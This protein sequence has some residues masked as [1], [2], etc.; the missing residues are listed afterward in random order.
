MTYT[1]AYLEYLE[2]DEWKAKRAAKL[3]EVGGKCEKWTAKDCDCAGLLQ[4]HHKNYDRLGHELMSDLMVL[5]EHHHK[6]EDQKRQFEAARMRHDKA[7][8]SYASKK[9]GEMWNEY[10]NADM[11]TEEFD[12]WAAR[13]NHEQ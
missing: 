12:N 10:V 9:Y 3:A 11:V 8:D 7:V 2:S 4:V 1:R 6:E 5:C 13:R